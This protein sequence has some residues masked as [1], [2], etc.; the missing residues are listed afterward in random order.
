MTASMGALAFAM[1]AKGSTS[2]MGAPRW[3]PNLN[4]GPDMAPK[5]PTLG[6]ARETRAAPRPTPNARSGPG[7][8][9]RS[10]T[11]RR[12][13]GRPGQAVASLG[14]SDRLLELDGQES[15]AQR[16]RHR[17]RAARRPELRQDRGDVKLHRVARDG[18]A[19]GDDPV[20]GAVGHQLENLT[21][22]RGQRRSRGRGA[23][24]CRRQGLLMDNEEAGADGAHGAGELL[25]L[26]VERQ[27]R[28]Q[29]AR[30]GRGR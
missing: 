5:P 6:A 30:T 2:D 3:P 27:R 25:R 29:S 19:R 10:S 26:R 22:T 8:P 14:Y 13:S 20:V 12:R 7:N 16:P 4:G 21:L 17:L 24:R 23:G 15:A 11:H 18:Q 28:A 1:K 9:G